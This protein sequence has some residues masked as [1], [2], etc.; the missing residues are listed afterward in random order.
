M[1]GYAR[2]IAVFTTISLLLSVILSVACL[3]WA[4]DVP[5]LTGRVV[6]F[7][8]V[9]PGPVKAGLESRLAAH[10]SRTSNQV[11]VLTLTSLEGQPL[12][13][14]SHRVASTWRLGQKGTDNGVLVLVALKERK[15]RIEVGY[16][17]EG[18]LTDAKSSRI[19]RHEMVPHFRN[20]DY[21]RGISAG[22]NAIL[23]TIEGTYNGP[24]RVRS[25]NYDKPNLGKV[26]GDIFF[27]VFIG[28]IVGAFMGGRSMW[29]GSSIGVLV[30]FLLALGS[31]LWFGVVAALI[32]TILLSCIFGMARHGGQV[33]RFYSSRWNSLS[34]GGYSGG[35][36]GSFGGGFSGGGFSGGGGGFG[37]GGASGGW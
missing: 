8:N 35:W 37:G 7:A 4:L 9:L 16:G 23:Q 2:R 29:S 15:I 20:G 3:S 17:L 32:T 21:D 31:G 6:D 18:T 33:D 10:E 24:H 19:I 1:K 14:F 22:V 13:E 36:G 12:E 25:T 11:A 30:S 27:A 26:F 28:T 34:R 5:P